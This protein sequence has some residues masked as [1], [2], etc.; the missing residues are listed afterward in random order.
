MIESKIIEWVDAH[1]QGFAF[2]VNTV[3]IFDPVKRVHRKPSKWIKKGT[4]DVIGMWKDK[5]LAIEVKKPGARTD[6]KRLADQKKFLQ[7]VRDRGGIAF[8]ADSLE[9][10]IKRLEYFDKTG[11]QIV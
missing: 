2:K 11:M 3:G 5:F 7:E 6:P 8:I 10:V 4:A 1:P 9:E